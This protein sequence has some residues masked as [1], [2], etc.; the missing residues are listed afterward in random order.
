MNSQ[1]LPNHAPASWTAAVLCRFVACCLLTTFLAAANDP[2][3]RRVLL[4]VRISNAGSLGIRVD[5]IFPNTT[6]SASG[7]KLNDIILLLDGNTVDSVPRF[8][9]YL[10]AK[11][12]GEEVTALPQRTNSKDPSAMRSSPKPSSG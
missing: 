6:A 2:L 4:G 12:P 1:G 9:E 8:L 3:P 5:Q 11:Q 7:L 10:K